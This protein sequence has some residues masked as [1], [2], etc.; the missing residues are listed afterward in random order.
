MIYSTPTATLVRKS[1][2]HPW[3]AVGNALLLARLARLDPS[4]ERARLIGFLGDA[5][6]VDAARLVPE[7]S[8]SGFAEWMT[9]RRAQ[10]HEF[11]GPYRLGATPPFDCESL[12][13][14]VRAL[15]PAV[16]VET[17]VCY[18]VS[19]AYILEALA[20]NGSGSLY[21]IDIGNSPDEPPNDFF[22]PPPLRAR[23]Q[24]I[25][26]DSRQELPRLLARLK[27]IDLFHHDS[28]HTREHMMWEYGA[29]LPYIRRNGI[30]SSHDVRTITS[31][32][33]LFRCNPFEEF[34]E[35]NGLL[36]SEAGNLGAAVRC[37]SVKGGQRR[38]PAATHGLG[39]GARFPA[40]SVLG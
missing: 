5:C 15:Q 27:Q 39:D 22:V 31:L 25:I 29:A 38:G 12:Y 10:L 35:R 21:S 13:L 23:W 24:L 11:D 9:R 19:S 18:G 30:L 14:L 8:Q 17:G 37:R 3:R 32:R 6:N 33:T 36:R 26:G 2:R 20:R 4:R 40:N 34:C 28:L 16:V 1:L 7:I